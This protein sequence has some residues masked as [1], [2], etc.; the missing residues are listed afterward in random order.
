MKIEIPL[1][2]KQ[3]PHTIGSLVTEYDWTNEET[4]ELVLCHDQATWL[5]RF[6]G[7][8][9]ATLVNSTKRVP[10]A[11]KGRTSEH[12]RPQCRWVQL[13]GLGKKARKGLLDSDGEVMLYDALADPLC[14]LLGG[15]PEEGTP[16][17]Y[18]IEL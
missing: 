17:W 3:R 8:Q 18:W 10:E 15:A 6:G 7:A 9:N 4:G 11:W 1:W 14:K 13:L 5:W 16:F 2:K 12:T